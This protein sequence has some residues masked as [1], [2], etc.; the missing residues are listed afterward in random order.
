MVGWLLRLVLRLALDPSGNLRSLLGIGRLCDSILWRIGGRL[1]GYALYGVNGDGIVGA[2]PFHLA[3]LVGVRPCGRNE[4]DL[5]KRSERK[6]K[7]L[8]HPVNSGA[9]EGDECFLHL[10]VG[11]GKDEVCLFPLVSG[12]LALPFAD[13]AN[14]M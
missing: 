8:V 2:K 5:D 12:G 7:E 9:G 6:G 3:F 10:V 1:N 13:I 14:P 4:G 11:V